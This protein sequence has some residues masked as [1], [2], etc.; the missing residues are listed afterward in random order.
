[1]NATDG[2]GRLLDRITA[3]VGLNCGYYRE[4]Y[5][6]R[7]LQIRMDACRTKTFGEYAE[8]L[9]IH[10]G[11]YTDLL[12]CIGVNFSEF[13]RDVRVFQTIAGTVLPEVIGRA[14]LAGSPSVRVLSAPCATGEEPYSFAIMLRELMSRSND[15]IKVQIHGV[16]IDEGA[17]AEAR[18]AVYPLHRLAQVGDQLRDKYFMSLDGGKYRVAGEIR[19]MVTLKRV[20][21]MAERLHSSYDIVLCRNM[22]IYVREEFHHRLLDEIT[23]A[24]RPG[25]YLILGATETLPA[26]CRPRFS[27]IAE[28][29]RIFR[30]AASPEND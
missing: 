23:R 5:L 29:E 11:E 27:Q 15:G 24:L 26:F 30:K 21:L 4:Q 18:E 9:R 28:K 6:R 3:D 25:G 10:P 19:Q 14:R 17:L 7:R 20:D 12:N 8:H 1:M 16:D 22:L 13:F 2:F